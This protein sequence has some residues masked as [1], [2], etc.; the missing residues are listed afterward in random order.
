MKLVLCRQCHKTG[1]SKEIMAR[2]IMLAF[3]IFAAATLVQAAVASRAF[4]WGSR[5]S[6][7]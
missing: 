7:R 2:S 1:G 6:A 5:P 3:T 4:F